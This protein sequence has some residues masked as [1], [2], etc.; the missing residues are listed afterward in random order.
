METLHGFDFF[1]VN[2]D[3]DGKRISATEWQALKQRI[4]SDQVTDVMFLAHGFRNDERDARDL[5]AEFLQNFRQHMD[6]RAELA[7]LNARRFVV[8]GVFWPSKAFRESF[9]TSEG[10]VLSADAQT[11]ELDDARRQL[12]ELRALVSSPADRK[13]LDD[14]EALLPT[15]E[16][17]PDAQDRFADLVLGIIDESSIDPTEGLQR[18]KSQPGS[19]LLDKLTMPIVLP[20]ERPGDGDGGVAAV[21]DADVVVPGA[22]GGAQ[23]IGSFFGSIFGRV[24]KLLNLTTWYLMKERSGTVGATGV[25]ASVRELRQ[26]HPTL[27]LHLIGHSL[28]GRLVTAC[29]KALASPPAVTIDSLLLLQAAFSHFG[30]AAD[31]R[32]GVPGFFRDVLGQRVVDGPMVATFSFQDEV[33]GKAYAIASRLAGDNVRQIGD[34]DDPY[35]GIGRNGAQNM[36]AAEWLEERLH[37]VGTTYSF[38][39]SRVH[40]LDG[41]G[42]LIRDHSDI[43]NPRVTY[44]AAS[45]IAIT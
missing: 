42:G 11:A 25:A 2:F 16:Q 5:Y 24:G 39:P 8:V 9:G 19:A 17:N 30:L 12:Q 15:L 28:G 3:G 41:T 7:P 27:K 40:G 29:A 44:A 38:R 13:K 36:T 10:G 35:G 1:P 32:D 18:V 43:R 4:E 14:A 23:G 37:D 22:G 31:N 45:A 33:V 26:A 21:S 34:R 6:Q 20:T